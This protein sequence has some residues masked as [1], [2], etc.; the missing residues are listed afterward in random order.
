MQKNV[1]ENLVIFLM[2]YYNRKQEEGVIMKL[3]DIKS[4]MQSRI[5]KQIRLIFLLS[6]VLPVLILG[7]F[8]TFHIRQQMLSRYTDLTHADGIRVNSI[9][10]ELT[11]ATYTSLEQ[12]LQ[13]RNYM[14]LFGS[15]FT[16]EK[17]Q[18]NYQTLYNS[19]QYLQNSLASVSSIHIYTNNPRIKSTDYI[20]Y[21]S[22]YS[23]QNWYQNLPEGTWQTWTCSTRTTSSNQRVTELCLVQRIGVVSDKYSA[24]AILCIDNNYLRNRLEQN[25]HEIMISVDGDTLFY[26]TD[27]YHLEETMPFPS[28]YSGGYYKYNGPIT[29]HDISALS[30][31]LTVQSY[32]TNNYFYVNVIDY[33]AYPSINRLMII[34]IGLIILIM[35][36]PSIII[37]VFSSYFS[38]RIDTLKYAMHQASLGD[39]NIIDTFHG[40][41]ELAETFHDLKSTVD[42]I[43]QNNSIYYQTILNNQEL[44]NRQQQM[45]YNMLASQINPHFLYNTLETI[46]MQALTSNCAD[47]ATSIKL[48]GKSM[49][50]V[51]ENTGTNTTTLANELDYIQTYLAIQ[52][53][54][55]GDRV[56]ADLQI[57]P[58]IDLQTTRILPLL[59]Q[60]I[61]E[62]AILHGLEDIYGSGLVTISIQL[63]DTLL[64]VNISDN[65]TGMSA[66]TLEQVRKNIHIQKSED[67]KSIGLYNINQRIQLF[68]GSQYQLTVQSTPESGTT[69]SFQIPS[70]TLNS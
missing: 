33:S 67:S 62:N 64:V 8:S 50:Y 52:K 10:F 21:S 25:D 7:I 32:K 13:N 38:N 17:D 58:N 37:T 49:R 60:P 43:N 30:S 14:S 45:E 1:Y 46:R 39:Y 40:D 55:F 26:A 15:D 28:D 31:I 63:Q 59:L 42:Q 29:L 2:F 34:Y 20:S 18:S 23:E 41:D 19:L 56:N 9:L 44:V 3:K 57:D 24:Y 47:V 35:V 12:I 6:V 5:K 22:D 70:F 54:R 65:G 4:G 66:E 68:Y 11:T 36:I 69:V 61:V 48:L 53:L 51:L 27:H 16:S